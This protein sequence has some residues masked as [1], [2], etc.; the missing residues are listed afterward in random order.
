[1]KGHKRRAM[2]EYVRKNTRTHYSPSEAVE[3]ISSLLSPYYPHCR[4]EFYED[5]AKIRNSYLVRSGLIRHQVCAVIAATEL[6]KRSFENM[7]AEWLLHNV[8]YY[9]HI[10]RSA[11]VDVDLDYISDRRF[12]V[13]FVTWI[14]DILDME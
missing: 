2:L 6:S 11:A 8:C 13:N 9:L 3:E 1:M 12:L 10:K 7:S 4:V 14:M 5:A